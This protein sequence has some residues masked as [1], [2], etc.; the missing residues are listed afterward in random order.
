MIFVSSDYYNC[1]NEYSVVLLCNHV[2]SGVARMRKLRG[3][4]LGTLLK[5]VSGGVMRLYGGCKAAKSAILGLCNCS[6]AQF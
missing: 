6:A 2:G 4:C 1:M 5:A 3:N